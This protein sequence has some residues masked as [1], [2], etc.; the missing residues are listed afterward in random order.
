MKFI[1][2]KLLKTNILSAFLVILLLCLLNIPVFAANNEFVV[3]IDA[4]HGG[5][6]HGAID[7][8]AREKDINLSVA[9][10]LGE[11]IEKKIKNS[12][13]VYTRNNDTFVS[14]QGRADIANKA[15]ADLFIS[16]HTNSVDTSNK[17]RTT[18]EGASVYTLGAQK[19]EANMSVARREN[20][21]IEL[22]SGSNSKYSG[23]DPN[24][25][26]SYI[27]FEM[28]QKNNLA[29]SNRFAKMVQ[30]NLVKI[31]GRKDRGVHQA[32]FW[33]L[34]STSMPS[35]LVELDF[36]CN[37]TSAKF[38]TSKEGVDKMADAIF[39]AVK[40]YEQNLRQSERMAANSSNKNDKNKKAGPVNK[41][42]I[43]A[44]TKEIASI[45]DEENLNE[46]VIEPGSTVALGFVPENTE[47]DM[48]HAEL[49]A[50]R[51]QK[52]A[53]HSSDGRRRRSLASKSISDSRN[54]E[55]I[56]NE[57][58]E[59]TGRSE[60]YSESKVEV[61]DAEESAQLTKKNKATKKSSKKISTKKYADVKG[62]NRS[63]SSQS[64]S[65]DKA[66][67]NSDSK[68]VTSK[69]KNVKEADKDRKQSKKEREIAERER[70]QKERMQKAQ[71]QRV[72][73]DKNVKAAEN[74][75]NVAKKA[76]PAKK[77][78]NNNQ[79]KVSSKP[80]NKVEKITEMDEE[81]AAKRKSLKSKSR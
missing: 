16:I 38:L 53:R 39:Q 52:R 14:L 19:D 48:S 4:G 1:F 61:A 46:D 58:H 74:A 66:G 60:N 28:A 21:V 59:Y 31:A 8:S 63:K 72:N 77:A 75:G 69:S 44:E 71:S 10:K 57:C 32:G 20:S 55:G 3:A 51:N 34:W 5:K 68:S 64:D 73:K 41:K 23:F 35:V 79:Q 42:N 62:S 15:K 6:D 33:V 17:N 24:K 45:K 26:E 78:E 54:L 70:I 76:Q 9:L 29:Q 47:K 27:I 67:N 56:V 36:I 30:D 13:V 65:H 37:P 43:K 18:V 12:K 80:E 7:N 25:D 11:L 2:H 40:I 81:H 22:E 50:T 49:S